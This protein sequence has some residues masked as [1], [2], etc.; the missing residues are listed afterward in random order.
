M[1]RMHAH[2]GRVLAC[3]LLLGLLFASLVSSA[4]AVTRDQ[5]VSLATEQVL[6]GSL[7]EVRLYVAPQALATGEAVRNWHSTVFTAPA[8]GWL[9]FIDLHPG[10]NWEHGCLYVFV[11]AATGAITRHESVTPPRQQELL[12]EVTQGRDNPPPGASE[13]AHRWLDTRLA[14]RAPQALSGSGEAYAFIISGGANSSNNHIRYWN[15]CSFIYKALT[16]VYGY[17]DD[18]IRVCMSDG[19]NPA[20]DR[21]DGTDSPT[22]LDGD[23][24][25]DIEYPATSEYIDQVFDELAATLTADDQLFLFTTDHGAQES[26]YA[27][28]LNLWNFEEL[29]DH[30]LAAYID[31]LPCETI[32]CTFEQCFSGGMVDDL[33]GDGRIIATAASWDQYSWAMPPDYVYDEFVYYWISAVAGQT[34]TGTP[35][36]ADTDD[37]GAVSM[38]EAFLYAQDQDSA[39]E[40]PQYSSTPSGLGDDVVLGEGSGA[41]GTL[42]TEDFETGTVPGAVWAATDTDSHGGLDYWGEQ[43]SCD[44][45]RVHGGSYSAYCADNSNIAGQKYDNYMNAT[46]TLLDPIDLSGYTDIELSFWVWCYSYSSADYLSFQVWNGSRWTERQRWSS[47]HSP[48]WVNASY[49]V[50]GNSLKFRFVFVSNSSG[51]R[52]GAYVDDIVVTGTSGDWAFSGP[53]TLVSMSQSAQPGVSGAEPTAAI[54]ST[55]ADGALRINWSQGSRTTAELDFSLAQPGDT[56]LDLF[57]VDGR[58]IRRLQDGPLASGSHTVAW[59]GATATGTAAAPGVYYARLTV[60]GSVSDTRPL[61]LVR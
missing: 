18:H 43:A 4:R 57:A 58:L 48:A 37:D 26:G 30:Q 50:T 39:E 13:A 51:T 27:C 56:R 35:V 31:A 24:D 6:G 7:A 36:D 42:F 53:T 38:R 21:S 25:A 9:V 23:G 1:P 3:A 47:S 40:S 19:T 45:A 33:A 59:D 49:A 2:H 12:V 34:P 44:G 5:A 11:D 61:L 55:P 14:G 41:S 32:I 22:D 17:A 54:E 52:E 15:D 10:A 29:H 46:L 60:D 8:E 20:I 16:Q 28:Y